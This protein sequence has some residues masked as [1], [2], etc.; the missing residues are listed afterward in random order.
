MV[1]YARISRKMVNPRG[2]AGNIE[3]E[4]DEETHVKAVPQKSVPDA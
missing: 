4:E 2:I 1:T 3:K